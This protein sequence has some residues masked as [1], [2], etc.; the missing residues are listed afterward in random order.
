MVGFNRPVPTAPT[1][2]DGFDGDGQNYIRAIQLLLKADGWYNGT[3]DGLWGPNTNEAYYDWQNANGLGQ[4]GC[5]GPHDANEAQLHIDPDSG[6]RELPDPYTYDGLSVDRDYR[7]HEVSSPSQRHY[8]SLYLGTSPR[9][10]I[11]CQWIFG[12]IDKIHY[13]GCNYKH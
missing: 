7:T 1:P 9:I 8:E 5:F 4:D 3:I 10:F 11:I 12:T 2:F 13:I 6:F